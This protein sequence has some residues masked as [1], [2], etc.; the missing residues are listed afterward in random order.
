LKKGTAQQS[1]SLNSRSGQAATNIS[2][3]SFAVDTRG[4]RGIN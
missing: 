4:N 1:D 2:K 3:G